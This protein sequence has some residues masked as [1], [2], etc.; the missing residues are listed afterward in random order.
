MQARLTAVTE[1]T[2]REGQSATPSDVL[3]EVRRLGLWTPGEAAV[4][5]R[6]DRDGR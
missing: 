2:A 4:I 6:A 5:L 1:A 3:A